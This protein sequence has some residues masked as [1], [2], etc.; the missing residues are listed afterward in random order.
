MTEQRRG[1][2]ENEEGLATGREYPLPTAL[3]TSTP[4]FLRR[5]LLVSWEFFSS[6]GTYISAKQSLIYHW[7][8]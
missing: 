6:R 7:E 1:S 2:M 8:N 4:Q 5:L 3:P